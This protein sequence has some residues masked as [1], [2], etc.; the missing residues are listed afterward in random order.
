MKSGL[1]FLTFNDRSS[2]GVSWTCTPGQKPG[3]GVDEM[4][5]FSDMRSI[6]VSEPAQHSW[7]LS[8]DTV[9]LFPQ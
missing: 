6:G 4:P 8:G 5:T 2:C 7:I 3:S 1:L 9:P